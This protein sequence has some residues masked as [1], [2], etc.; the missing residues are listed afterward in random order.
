MF[1]VN[2]WMIVRTDFSVHPVT[3]SGNAAIK[4]KAVSSELKAFSS[5]IFFT[6]VSVKITLKCNDV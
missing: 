6:P 5:N 4:E 2:E 3:R 1:E